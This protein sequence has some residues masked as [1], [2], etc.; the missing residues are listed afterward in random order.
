MSDRKQFL[1]VMLVAAI[2]I[3]WLSW[4]GIEVISLNNHLQDDPKLSGYPYQFRV[5]RVEGDT[6]IMSSPRSYE[7]STQDALRAL[8]PSLRSLS[9]DHRDWQRA[10]REFAHLQ[11]HA[12]NLVLAD[13]RIDKIRWELDRNWYHLK[14]MDPSG[15][16]AY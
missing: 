16:P 14:Q 13:E 11:A 1:I 7:V 6:A 8:F 9:D 15:K 12:G 5:L 3:G 4:R 2:F 10:E